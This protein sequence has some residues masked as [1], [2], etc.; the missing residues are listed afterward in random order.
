MSEFHL[1]KIRI[2]SLEGVFLTGEMQAWWR[3]GTPAGGRER[4]QVKSGGPGY[5]PRGSPFKAECLRIPVLRR[6]F[7]ADAEK[8]SCLKDEARS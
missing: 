3:P 8:D 5:A 6:L 4:S 1:S 2:W 7:C